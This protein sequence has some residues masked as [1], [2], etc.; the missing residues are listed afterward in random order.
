METELTMTW[1]QKPC[2]HRY[3]K[4]YG[5]TQSSIASHWPPITRLLNN[6]WWWQLSTGETSGQPPCWSHTTAC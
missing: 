4:W 3:A 2:G 1:H 6:M 5:M